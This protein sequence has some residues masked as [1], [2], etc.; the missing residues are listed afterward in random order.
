LLI[1]ATS[2]G[3][4]GWGAREHTWLMEDE[5]DKHQPAPIDGGG[6]T[7]GQIADTVGVWTLLFSVPFGIV[8]IIGLP[9]ATTLIWYAVVLISTA[10][11]VRV[12]LTLLGLNHGRFDGLGNIVASVR[13]STLRDKA[14]LVILSFV[15]ID[16]VVLARPLAARAQ[17]NVDSSCTGPYILVGEGN[18][19]LTE[20]FQSVYTRHGGSAR[21]GCPKNPVSVI[22]AGY[23]QN[24]LGPAGA[25]AIFATVP[26][27]VSLLEGEFHECYVAIGGG[28]GV[29]SVIRAGYPYNEGV[30]IPGGWRLDLGAGGKSRSGILKRGGEECYWVPGEL[31]LPYH[32]KFGGPAGSLGYPISDPEP[33][34]GGGIR[35]EFEGGPLCHTIQ[36]TRC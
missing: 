12:I 18:A 22:E 3:L 33:L 6:L 5:Q 14:I 16:L 21:I 11:V 30:A 19:E 31:W 25:S 7:L 1:K 28:N 17:L 23:H 13:N 34:E 4:A 29:E 35:Q 27:N 10:L 15:A 32:E 36:T 24:F 20:A 26:E 2:Y 8:T 9:V